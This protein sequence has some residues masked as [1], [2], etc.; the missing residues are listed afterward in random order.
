M[1]TGPRPRDNPHVWRLAR[2]PADDSVRA[3]AEI[4][5]EPAISWGR[6]L[7]NRPDSF[8]R[9]R[10]TTAIKF[11]SLTILRGCPV[12]RSI[13]TIRRC[14][15]YPGKPN[16]TKEFTGISHNARTDSGSVRR[17]K[18]LT[19]VYTSRCDAERDGRSVDLRESPSTQQSP[20][21]RR[22]MDHSWLSG[23]CSMARFLLL[24]LWPNSRTLARALS[25]DG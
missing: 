24:G 23:N 7:I 15:V 22:E 21:I 9:R 19:N 2:I 4:S 12:A 18:S 25:V 6:L 11:H 10:H 17:G 20:V 8:P 14:S 13:Q 5:W 1:G 16:R 3:L